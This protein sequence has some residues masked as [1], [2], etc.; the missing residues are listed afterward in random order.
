MEKRYDFR[1][2]P[3]K[4]QESQ[5]QKNFGCCRFVY[6]YYL[7]KRME[8][9]EQG[10]GILGL[11]ECERDLTR[12]KQTE[13]YEWLAEADA[14]ALLAALKD[15]DLAYKAFFR[16]VREGGTPGFPRFKQKRNGRKSYKSRKNVKRSNIQAEAGRIKLPKL[17]WV[18]YKDSRPLEGRILSATVSQARSGK[19]FVSLCCTEVE[20]RPWPKTGA[21]LGLHLGIRDLAATSLG[22]H[23]ENPRYF[24]KSAKKITRLHR[25]L[26]RKP[27]DSQNR[28]KAR[29][30]LARAYEKVT[31]Q[32]SDYLNKLS[33]QLVRDYDMICLRDT[34]VSQVLKDRRFAKLVSDAGWGEFMG[35]LR[36]KCKWYGKELRLTEQGYP[37]AQI[38]SVCG[39]LNPKV[40]GGSGLQEWDCP[41]C[42]TRHNRGVNAARNV[43]REAL[44]GVPA[45]GAEAAPGKAPG[46]AGAAEAAS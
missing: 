5:M 26:S 37:S 46:K 43:L 29:I 19:Y 24:E 41:Q 21:A 1:I 42:G 28:E 14:N 4:K 31:H 36:Y 39:A 35:Q 17:G 32:R 25:R 22:E 7:A 18:R 34:K 23:I 20:P 9:Y 12:L 15:L 27:K 6:N 2:Y 8:A 13:G 33:S 40:K 38:C 30:Q 44:E 45:S 3:S 10:R 11:N 16:R